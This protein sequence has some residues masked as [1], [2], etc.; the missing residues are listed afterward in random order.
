MKRLSDLNI[1]W[2]RVWRKLKD[3]NPT[4]KINA[5]PRTIGTH[6][7]NFRIWRTEHPTSAI[8]PSGAHLAELERNFRLLRH[9]N[10]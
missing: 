8:D 9:E 1:E 6:Q 4:S 10:P 3:A 2:T 5:N 7:R